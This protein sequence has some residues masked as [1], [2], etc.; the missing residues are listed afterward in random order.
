MRF[1][2]LL[3]QLHQQ[4]RYA[5]EPRFQTEL[6]LLKLVE[7]GGL[8]AIEERLARAESG[9]ATG[10]AASAGSPPRGTSAPGGTPAAPS[11]GPASAGPERATRPPRLSPFQPD[12]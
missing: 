10:E 3:L 7:G 11:G 6:G 8:G 12:T 5:M 1:L 4:L 2:D 9:G